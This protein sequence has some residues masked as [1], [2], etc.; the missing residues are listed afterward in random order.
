MGHLSMDS[1]WEQ[2]LHQN[3]AFIFNLALSRMEHVVVTMVPY[4]INTPHNDGF[5]GL[6]PAG[7]SGAGA[8]H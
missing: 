1:F 5:L 4:Q 2:A 7:S 8:A 3:S 6:N